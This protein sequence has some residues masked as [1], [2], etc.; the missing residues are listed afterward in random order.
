MGLW[1]KCD[2]K[3]YPDSSFVHRRKLSFVNVRAIETGKYV[4]VNARVIK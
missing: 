1:I 4:Y 2:T 3:N